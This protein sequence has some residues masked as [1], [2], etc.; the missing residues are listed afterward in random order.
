M[1]S[2]ANLHPGEMG[3][4]VGPVLDDLTRPLV[5]LRWAAYQAAGAPYGH[6]EAELWRRATE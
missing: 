4:V 6:D 3:S 1:E 5:H 2:V